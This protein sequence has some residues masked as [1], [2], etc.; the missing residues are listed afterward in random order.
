[1]LDTS[2]S[3]NSGYIDEHNPLICP[4]CKFC[5]LTIAQ[6]KGQTFLAWRF[7]GRGI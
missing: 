3:N 4:G 7:I 6:H 2:A 1:M 5:Y